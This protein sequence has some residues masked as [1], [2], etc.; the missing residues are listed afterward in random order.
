MMHRRLLIAAFL[1]GLGTF[2]GCSRGGRPLGRVSGFVTYE[3]NAVP[4]GTIVFMPVESGPPAY[5]NLGPDGH[6]T[7][8]TFSSEDGAVVGKHLVMITAFEKL[9]PEEAN[10]IKRMPKMLIPAKYNDA[11]KSKLT[12]EVSAGDN[13]ISFPLIASE[14]IVPNKR[15]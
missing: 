5:G 1:V 15:R 14:K 11:K 7:L 3:G 12:A 10:N 2:A 6:Y 8:S 13:E 4:N 9:T